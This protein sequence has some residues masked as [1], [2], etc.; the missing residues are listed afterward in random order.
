MRERG[1]GEG[2]GG[3]R[4]VMSVRQ[5][6]W[7]GAGV[8]GGDGGKRRGKRRVKGRLCGVVQVVIITLHLLLYHFLALAGLRAGERGKWRIG[9]RGWGL[10]MCVRTLTPLLSFEE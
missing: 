7:V 4:G 6:R 1:R 3:G 2:R 9:D 10:C 8:R 5:V